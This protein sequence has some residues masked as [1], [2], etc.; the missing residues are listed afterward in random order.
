MTKQ[1]VLAVFAKAGGFL[2]P[3]EARKYLR[4]SLDRRSFYSYLLRLARQGL[5][6]QKR[7][8]SDR[9]VVY[10][11]TPRGFARLRYFRQR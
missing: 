8:M 5:L 2:K 1:E 4:T 3:D 6:E 11:L 10:R 7:T 9:R